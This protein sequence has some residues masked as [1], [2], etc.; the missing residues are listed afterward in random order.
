MAM[1]RKNREKEMASVLLTSLSF[2]AEGFVN[3][4]V[5]LVETADDTVLDIPDVV[6]DLSMFLARAV[7]DEVLILQYLEEIGA[8]CT[9]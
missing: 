1:D 6:E 3:D 4:F 8:Q 5:M 9:G 7:V 2:P